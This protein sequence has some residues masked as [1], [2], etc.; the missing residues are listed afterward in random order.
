MKSDRFNQVGGAGNGGTSPRPQVARP[1]P[2]LSEAASDV[3]RRLTVTVIWRTSVTA[4]APIDAAPRPAAGLTPPRRAADGTTWPLKT[5][6][7]VAFCC[8]C[9]MSDHLVTAGS[10]LRADG[11]NW[12]LTY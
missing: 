3:W 12:E 5:A 10:G 11:S 1:G 7:I 2:F 6:L 9:Q 8:G 4:A